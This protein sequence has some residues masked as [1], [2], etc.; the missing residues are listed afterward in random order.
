MQG[1]LIS[2]LLTGLT[3]FLLP[4]SLAAQEIERGDIVEFQFMGETVQAKVRGFDPDEH[5]IV[6]F[7]YQRR[8]I[9][10]SI[11]EARLSVVEIVTE[12]TQQNDPNDPDNPFGK[13]M[14]GS[15]LPS[16]DN[17]AADNSDNPFAKPASPAGSN[18]S[19]KESSDNNASDPDN[20][21]TKKLNA[22]DDSPFGA[23]APN[24]ERSAL[25]SRGSNSASDAENPFTKKMGSP[26]SFPTSNSSN[27]TA[28]ASS[29][30]ND[31]SNPFGNAVTGR[32]SED[33]LK[34]LSKRA[35]PLDSSANAIE[36]SNTVWKVKTKGVK[37][38]P[39]DGSLEFQL[40]AMDKEFHNEFSALVASA[41]GKFASI[42]VANA[43]EKESKCLFMDLESGDVR[44]FAIPYKD[45]SVLAISPSGQRVLTVG[46]DQADEMVELWNSDDFGRSYETWPFR[47]HDHR[48]PRLAVESATFVSENKLL[49]IGR[50]TALWDL[51]SHTAVYSCRARSKAVAICPSARYFA[52]PDQEHV[53]VIESTTGTV[54]GRISS[55]GYVDRLAFSPN[56]RY[57]AGFGGKD[58]WIWDLEEN[59]LDIKFDFDAS[60]SLESQK[61]RWVGN[62]HLLINGSTLIGRLRGETLATFQQNKRRSKYNRNLQFVSTR[63]GRFWIRSTKKLVPFDLLSEVQSGRGGARMLTPEGLE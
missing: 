31:M 56:G 16:A 35:K 21:F 42:A 45:G 61:I 3:V 15:R 23:P 36:L 46:K 53:Y 12:E 38:T 30:S 54:H 14:R 44:Q 47:F 4:I 32:S 8:R 24:S 43:F 55:I 52:V 41:N 51:R 11:L 17:E 7:R 37:K 19:G 20:P 27:E 25:K 33:S 18:S 34:E 22:N 50:R 5:P 6:L 29:R 62:D 59:R 28:V 9:E 60:P 13:Q 1:N 48:I 39:F 63:H 10:R 58:G 57:L 40:P 49:T 26:E 2:I